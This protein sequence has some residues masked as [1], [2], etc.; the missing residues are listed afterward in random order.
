MSFHLLSAPRREAPAVVDEGGRTLNYGE[1]DERV[2]QSAAFLRSRGERQL[3]ALFSSNRLESLVAYLAAL[4]AG[5]VPILLPQG[6][7]EPLQQELLRTYAPAWTMGTGLGDERLPGSGIDL[8]W[9]ETDADAPALHPD[10]G[11]L[12]STSGTTGSARLVRLS[13]AAV[14]A[15][16][17]SIAQY[18]QLGEGERTVTTLPPSYSYGL[19]VLNSHLLAG[20]CLVLSE[21]SV[22]SREFWDLCEQQRPTSL[23][24]VPATH[25]MLQRAGIG[26]KALPSLRTLTQAGGALGDKLAA[27]MCALS[28]E[29]GWRFFVM[30]GQT[31]AT[32]RISYV[33]PEQ[34]ARKLGSI[35]VA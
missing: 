7:P 16:A 19:S 8:Q 29:R 31:E 35:G 5:H 22:L 20:G 4:R 25:Q 33:P 1:L 6:M 17:E 24:G 13:L 15:N 32:A 11:L 27:S 14:Q 21:H 2:T 28:A 26:Q 3:G 34:L 23:A 30:Y 10:L 18:L 12:L 9:A